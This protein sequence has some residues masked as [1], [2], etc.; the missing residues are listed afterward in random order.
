MQFFDN[1]VVSSFLARKVMS[2][3]LNLNLTDVLKAKDR[4]KRKKG[5]SSDSSDVLSAND[6]VRLGRKLSFSPAEIESCLKAAKM[7]PKT[8]SLDFAL[9]RD[10][11]PAFV[12]RL[13]VAEKLMGPYEQGPVE[14]KLKKA[15]K[16]EIALKE[17]MPDKPT[18]ATRRDVAH[19]RYEKRKKL[20]MR[21]RG[22][23]DKIDLWL[24]PKW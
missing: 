7:Q 11:V 2:N 10:D 23:E 16:E 20:K 8:N 17:R 18:W 14:P 3:R 12:A 9:A 5:Q 13:N 22:I 6:I 1:M 21:L 24:D 19:A 15:S 4:E